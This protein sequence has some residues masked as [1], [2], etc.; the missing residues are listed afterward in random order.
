MGHNLTGDLVRLALLAALL[1]MAGA[2][3][4]VPPGRHSAI[5]ATIEPA[6]EQVA[7]GR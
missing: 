2:A 3:P 7:H 4:F 5:V 1:A 6:R